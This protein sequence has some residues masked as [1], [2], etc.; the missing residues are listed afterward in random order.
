MK[1]RLFVMAG[2][3]AGLASPW[4]TEGA[5]ALGISAADARA[6]RATVQ[7]Q[8]EAFAQDDAVR[9]FGLAT[10]S[11]RMQVGSPDNFLKMVRENYT[12]IYRNRLALFS[13]PEV[14]HGKTVQMVRLTDGE[15]HVWLAIYQMEQD[16][17]KSWKVDGCQLLQTT[18]VSV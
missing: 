3:V 15:G 6:I 18:S 9:A 4:W 7:S 8:L 2:L 1:R 17:D 13:V 5:L 16:T 14:I 10:Q 12:P 11:T